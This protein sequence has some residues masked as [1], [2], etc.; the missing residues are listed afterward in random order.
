MAK[1]PPR[2][3]MNDVKDQLIAR[4]GKANQLLEERIE[5]AQH[6]LETY[7]NIKSQNVKLLA[8]SK[9]DSDEFLLD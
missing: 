1:R 4:I 3:K 9:A 2:S 5:E 7:Q 8:V 6:E